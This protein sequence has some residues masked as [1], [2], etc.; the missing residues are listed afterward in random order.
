MYP[1]AEFDGNMKSI[2]WNTVAKLPNAA[3]GHL[4]ATSQSS[5]RCA[6]PSWRPLGLEGFGETEGAYQLLVT[7]IFIGRR[8]LAL[9]QEQRSASV[10]T[11]SRSRGADDRHFICHSE[12]GQLGTTP[13]LSADQPPL[14]K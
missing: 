12:R 5:I 7:Y 3:T 8:S 6:I 2:D 1:L 11:Y 4:S 13:R 14:R 10:P 9:R